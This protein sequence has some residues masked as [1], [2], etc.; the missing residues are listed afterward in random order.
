MKK[1]NSYYQIVFQRTNLI[2]L[3]LLSFF[4]G[5]SSWPRIILEVFLRRGMG[6]RYM[7]LMTCI[8]L[9]VLM[10]FGTN[11][12]H[13]STYSGWSFPSVA[14]SFG[15]HPSEAIFA[16]VFLAMGI[17][18]YRETMSE[19]GVFE[20]AK[21]SHYSGDILP[22]YYNIKLFGIEP[23][24][25]LIS[26]VYE[27]LTGIAVGAILNLFD[28]PVGPLLIVCSIIYSL[29][30]FGAHYLGDQYLMD[31]IDEIMCS[32][33]L[34]KTLAEGMRPED[35][36]GV[37]FFGTVPPDKQFRRVLADSMIEN[38]PATDIV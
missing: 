1:H 28:S 8:T 19:P 22:F 10:F 6:Q 27:P 24:R 3:Y 16:L 30:Y 26:T 14:D 23:G 32:E 34:G 31:R 11:V 2:K 38:E 15:T 35:G 33:D 29:S 20:F 21:F 36:R 13:Y 25:R 9:F 7:S 5:I 37:E 12:P 18:R 17:M 4:L